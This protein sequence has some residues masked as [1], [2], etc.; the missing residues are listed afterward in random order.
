MAFDHILHD[1]IAISFSRTGSSVIGHERERE[2]ERIY[3]TMNREMG[4]G[5]ESM[6]SH[7]VPN[8]YQEFFEVE[9][10]SNLSLHN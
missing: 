10:H 8:T 4:P 5:A 2:R 6:Q 7:F 9:P 1:S 3:F